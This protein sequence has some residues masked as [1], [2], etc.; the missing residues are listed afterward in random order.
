MMVTGEKSAVEDLHQ[1]MKLAGSVS[2]PLL[3][4]LCSGAEPRWLWR[5]AYIYCHDLYP[6]DALEAFLQNS[7]NLISDLK[8]HRQDFDGVAALIVAE[9]TQED[10]IRGYSFSSTLIRA[11]AGID[12]SLEVDVL[13][14]VAAPHSNRNN[15]ENPDEK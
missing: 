6:E 9:G 12:A 8:I 2:K 5:T 15:D 3:G 14:R 10:F 11:L 1:R 7:P 4:G 13:H